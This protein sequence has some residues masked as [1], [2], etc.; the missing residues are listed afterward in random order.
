M[1]GQEKKQKDIE[2]LRRYVKAIREG[3]KAIKPGT[4]ERVID[5]FRES[6]NSI[7]EL[8]GIWRNIKKRRGFWER[9]FGKEK[10]AELERFYAEATETEPLYRTFYDDLQYWTLPKGKQ[11]KALTVAGN[12]IVDLNLLRIPAFAFR[13]TPETKNFVTYKETRVIHNKSISLVTRVGTAQGALTAFDYMVF[14]AVCSFI[15]VRETGKGEQYF[16][17]FTM[18]ELLRKIKKGWDYYKVAYE[19]LRKLP[20]LHIEFSHYFTEKD[21]EPEYLTMLYFEKAYAPSKNKP[22]REHIFLFNNT[23]GRVFSNKYYREFVFENIERFNEP[24][25]MRLYELLETELYKKPCLNMHIDDLAERIPLP[26]K[27][28]NRRKG[29]ILKTFKNLKPIFECEIDNKG[30]LK[31]WKGESLFKT[32]AG[33][34]E[35]EPASLPERAEVKIIEPEHIKPEDFF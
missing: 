10:V 32:P 23:A 16:S 17:A 13:K 8:K 7:Q 30:Y 15:K 33:T 1:T 25:T 24:L 28:T 9:E 34:G 6:L 35:P 27:N 18:T 14:R 29:K 26:D 21:T 12:Y 3:E 4:E 22:E 19:A 31:I 11:G 20:T 5:V 2:E